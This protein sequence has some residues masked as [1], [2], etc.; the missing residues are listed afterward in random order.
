MTQRICNRFVFITATLFVL[1]GCSA[2]FAASDIKGEPQT[3]D[4]QQAQLAPEQRDSALRLARA[5]RAAGDLASSVNLYR[6]VIAMK[7]ADP[8]V[9]VELGDTLLEVRNVDDA[10]DVYNQV[11]ET[12]SARLAALL[13]L[14]RAYFALGEFGKELEYADKAVALAPGDEKALIGCGVALDSLNRHE[15]AQTY[16]RNVISASPHNLAAR[17]NLALSLALSGKFEEASEIMTAIARSAPL[18]P[19][20]R[21]NL[22]LIYGLM[23]ERDRAKELSLVDLS[24]SDTE[25]NLR[26]F[27][28]VR[29]NDR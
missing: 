8:A 6:G 23:G 11:P 24:P 2:S 7:P 26:F 12:S 20:I 29:S 28:L 22:A 1:A 10:I 27:D 17:N 21:Q 18:T 13:G 14:E 15:E 25:T 4:I 19:R 3:Q 9:M 5:S 16:Y